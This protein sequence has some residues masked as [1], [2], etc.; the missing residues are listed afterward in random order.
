MRFIKN[1]WDFNKLLIAHLIITGIFIYSQLNSNI[2]IKNFND[3]IDIYGLSLFM[4]TVVYLTNVMIVVKIN[5]KVYQLITKFI[6]D[7]FYLKYKD[8]DFNIF[9]SFSIFSLSLYSMIILYDINFY[10]YIFLFGVSIFVTLM[11]IGVLDTLEKYE[12]EHTK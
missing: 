12:E 7:E 11:H 6:L 4:I 5:N 1:I 8:I 10:I 2:H 9:T 3:I